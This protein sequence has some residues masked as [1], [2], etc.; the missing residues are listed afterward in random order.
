MI[1]SRLAFPRW[2]RIA[3][4]VAFWLALLGVLAWRAWPQVSGALGVARGDLPVPDVELHSIDGQ[5]FSTADLRGQVV[6][7]NFW[8]T[9]CR[10]CRI[11][12]PGFEDVYRYHYRRPAGS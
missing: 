12:M 6:L 3:L 2:G 4:D 9:W 1:R 8:A 11:E 7:V 10:P 5:R